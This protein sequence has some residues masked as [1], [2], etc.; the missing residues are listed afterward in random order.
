[1]EVE[2]RRIVREEINH[3]EKK[4]SRVMLGLEDLHKS[5]DDLKMAYVKDS[6]MRANNELNRT[7]KT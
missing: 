3:L 2:V 7:D 6:F 4:V 5:I 1:M